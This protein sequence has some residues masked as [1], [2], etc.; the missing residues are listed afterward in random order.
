MIR[1]MAVWMQLQ[2]G[3]F[4]RLHEPGRQANRDA[5]LDPEMLAPA[6]REFQQAR[7]RQR[8]AVEIA[9]QGRARFIIGDAI[10]GINITIADAVLQRDAPLPAG[11]VRGGARVRRKIAAVCLGTAAARSHGS[12]WLQST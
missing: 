3:R 2:A 5:I 11:L 1:A 6:G 9:E 7:Q 12:Q 10:A 8:F 4:Q